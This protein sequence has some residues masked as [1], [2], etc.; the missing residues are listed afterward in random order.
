MF[1]SGFFWVVH[2]WGENRHGEEQLNMLSQTIKREQNI[3]KYRV[4]TELEH[5]WRTWVLRTE[6][7]RIQNTHHLKSIA[8]SCQRSGF[9][10]PGGSPGH[11]KVRPRSRW[12]LGMYSVDP[13]PFWWIPCDNNF[14]N[15]IRWDMIL[16][17]SDI[18]WLW[19]RAS[20][21]IVTVIEIYIQIHDYCMLL[22]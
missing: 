2:W 18:F 15:Q 17:Y 12:C 9:C 3:A 21:L 22:K 20:Y 5:K 7:D 19:L 11:V 16:T 10:A 13:G 8:P 6:S 1:P 14:Q 4:R